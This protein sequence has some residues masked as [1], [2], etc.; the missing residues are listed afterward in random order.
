[1]TTRMFSFRN[2]CFTQ[3]G[4]KAFAVKVKSIRCNLVDEPVI[5]DD[6]DVDGDLT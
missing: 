3:S 4:Q 5:R 1:M 6:E 2:S